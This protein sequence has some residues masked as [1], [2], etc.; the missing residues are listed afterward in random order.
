MDR[1]LWN[2]IEGVTI[3]MEPDSWSYSNGDMYMVSANYLFLY[4]SLG[5]LVKCP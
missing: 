1:N 2:L 5:R 4:N 3:T